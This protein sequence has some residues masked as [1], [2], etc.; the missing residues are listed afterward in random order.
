MKSFQR[1]QWVVE[2]WK[3]IKRDLFKKTFETREITTRDPQFWIRHNAKIIILPKIKTENGRKSVHFNG[4]KLVN[5]LP[6]EG[7]TLNK[8]D[9]SN[10]LDNHYNYLLFNLSA[11][12]K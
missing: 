4:G 5:M 3:Q 2:A 1:F 8:L 6:L 9:F 7:R 12:A 10:F 11:D